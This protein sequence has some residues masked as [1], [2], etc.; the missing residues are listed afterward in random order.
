[1]PDEADLG[2][3]LALLQTEL[4]IK[5]AMAQQAA[6]QKASEDCLFCGN[7][8]SQARRAVEARWCD[9]FCR[10]DWE[11]EQQLMRHIDAQG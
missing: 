7:R 2:N 1:M 3:D 10:D 5:E 8:L 4:A 6:Q 11:K 9:Q